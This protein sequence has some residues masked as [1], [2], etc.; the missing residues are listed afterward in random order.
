[1]EAP[2][3][4]RALLASGMTQVAI[5]EQTSIPQPT[6]SRIARGKAKD[7]PSKRARKLQAL[8]ELRLGGRER[9]ATLPEPKAA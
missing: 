3:Y 8:W 1:M 5:S 2:D 7:V 4:L 6:L 9:A